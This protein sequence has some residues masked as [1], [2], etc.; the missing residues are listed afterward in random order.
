MNSDFADDDVFKSVE[1]PCVNNNFNK[2]SNNT[3]DLLK[4]SRKY[5]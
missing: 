3:S 2:L 4:T 5:E 1:Y